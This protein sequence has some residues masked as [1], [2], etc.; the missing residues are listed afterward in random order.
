MPLSEN[1]RSAVV[2]K[3]C[4]AMFD[5]LRTVA[6]LDT[7]HIRAAV[8]A[9]DSMF[10]ATA[11]TLTQNQTVQANFVNA[12]P[13]PFKSSTNA[14]QKTLVFTYVAMKRGGVL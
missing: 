14:A 5:E 9:L 4:Q 11:S 13:E 3:A 2:R 8:D 6:N 12:L 1:E 7:S 10:D